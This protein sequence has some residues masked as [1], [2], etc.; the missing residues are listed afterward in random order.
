MRATGA[1][2]S[3]REGEKNETNDKLK[4]HSECFSRRLAGARHARLYGEV[5]LWREFF[6]EIME[7]YCG[8]KKVLILFQNVV[9]NN[10]INY[11]IHR[12]LKKTTKNLILNNS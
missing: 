1:I 4:A 11:H 7:R 10:N 2:K 6:V 12:N 5:K 3:S 9:F 8:L